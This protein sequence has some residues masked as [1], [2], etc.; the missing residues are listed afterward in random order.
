MGSAE[1]ISTIKECSIGQCST[2]EVRIGI[3]EITESGLERSGRFLQ[4][5]MKTFIS[6][7][8]MRS[9]QMVLSK[10]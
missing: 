8:A 1:Y 4:G 9:L 7:S 10:E 2:S 5:A 6:A 3:D